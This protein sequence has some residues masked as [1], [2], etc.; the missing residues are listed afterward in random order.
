MTSPTTVTISHK[1]GRAEAKRRIQSR[2]GEFANRIPGGAAQVD[3][4]WPTDSQM[5]MELVA[6]GQRLSGRLDIFD[7]EV[8]VTLMLPPLLSMMSGVIARAVK[9]QGGELLLGSDASR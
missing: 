1:L 3:T 5:S 7:T 9:A 2:L 4:S 6:M 8:V